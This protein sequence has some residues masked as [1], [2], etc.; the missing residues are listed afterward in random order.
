MT[1]T[2]R[3]LF[4]DNVLRLKE[5][6]DNSFDCCVTDGP[7]GLTF[8]NK[9]WDYDVPSVE[10]WRE[11]FR[12]LK[13]RGFLL[14]FGGTRTYHRM[15][16]NIEDA[17]FEIRDMIQWLYGSGFPKNMDIAKQLDKTA[18]AIRPTEKKMVG[19]INAGRYAGKESSPRVELDVSTKE[20]ITAKAKQ[21]DGWGT[22]LKPAN[23]PI[24]VARKPFPGTVAENILK[25]GTGGINI[26][27][28]RISFASE[29]DKA[30]AI[31]KNQHGDFGS[32]AR[33]NKIYGE[34]NSERDNYN[35]E[36]RWPANIILDEEAA[37]LLD[38]QTM[39][40]VGGA[41]R[42]FY[43]AK[44]SQYERNKGLGHLEKRKVNDGR[45][46]EIDNPFQRGE[47]ERSNTHVTVKP[48]SLMRY[49]IKLV[50]QKGGLVL[51]PFNGSG[52][53]GIAC[54][55]ELMNY[56]GIDND[57]ESCRISEARLAAWNPELYTPQTLF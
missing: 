15:V 34:D 35:S 23:E 43:V 48:V 16:V 21:W 28:S 7:Y 31:D 44:P 2:Q 22:A 49:L 38:E 29:A 26:H 5:F 11:V 13:P 27:E 1:T 10:L 51:D 54:K 57:A 37:L 52:S 41:S 9:K 8:M 55:L 40:E 32:G 56:V 20:P 17:G 50:T 30:E 47:T 6:P 45:Q 46:S 42:F 3:I 4:G 18:A 33:G 14:S 19:D 53:T 36:G 12:V 39:N 24:C 25:W